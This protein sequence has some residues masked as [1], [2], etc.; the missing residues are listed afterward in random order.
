M[1]QLNEVMNHIYGTD[2]F[3]RCEQNFMF[4]DDLLMFGVPPLQMVP[5]QTNLNPPPDCNLKCK[6]RN[7]VNQAISNVSE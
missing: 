3:P 7:K 5:R 4:I 6:Y 1:R 2:F